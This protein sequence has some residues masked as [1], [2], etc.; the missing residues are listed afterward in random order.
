MV[1][2]CLNIAEHTVT[3]KLTQNCP[4]VNF[5][6]P[7]LGTST[8]FLA[9]SSL[10][11]PLI[12]SRYVSLLGMEKQA[13]QKLVA[14]S[15]WLYLIC[16]WFCV[17]NKVNWMIFEGYTGIGCEAHKTVSR[18]PQDIKVC[19]FQEEQCWYGWGQMCRNQ[20]RHQ[21]CETQIPK[22]KTGKSWKKIFFFF[23][24]GCL[25]G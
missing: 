21:G 2:M 25:E 13:G 6:Q 20:C 4:Q 17:L 14:D 5:P 11:W 10:L 9:S 16:C 22:F 3:W 7:I 12:Y 24:L 23:F 1:V 15:T 18:L 8:V 19:M